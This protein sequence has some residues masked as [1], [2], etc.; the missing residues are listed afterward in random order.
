MTLALRLTLEK[1]GQSRRWRWRRKT[2]DNSEGGRRTRNV[3]D[4]DDDDDQDDEPGDEYVSDLPEAYEA[5]DEKGAQ[6]RMQLRG[7]GVKEELKKRVGFGEEKQECQREKSDWSWQTT[8]HGKPSVGRVYRGEEKR[9]RTATNKSLRSL[10]RTLLQPFC[11]GRVIDET[12]PTV[13]SSPPP[14]LATSLL[15]ER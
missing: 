9:K 15:R 13:L 11:P 4:E 2:D 8:L 12:H 5:L 3:R 10:C 14:P 7:L 6:R 1:E